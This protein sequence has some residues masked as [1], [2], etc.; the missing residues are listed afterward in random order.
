MKTMTVISALATSQRASLSC[1]KARLKKRPYVRAMT[2]A[3]YLR[4][5]AIIIPS[6]LTLHPLSYNQHHRCV[7]WLRQGPQG[8]CHA[9]GFAAA[10]PGAFISSALLGLAPVPFYP[11]FFALALHFCAHLTH[12]VWLLHR[13]F[14]KLVWSRSRMWWT[15]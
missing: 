5:G 10:A 15:A 1:R 2:Q 8:L 12:C 6:C 9:E 13:H 11:L 3:P 14:G 7:L 4:R